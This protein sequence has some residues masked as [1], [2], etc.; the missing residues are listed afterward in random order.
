MAGAWPSTV[1]ISPAVRLGKFFVRKMLLQEQLRAEC[2][3]QLPTRPLAL[4]SHPA[5][6][7]QHQPMPVLQPQRPSSSATPPSPVAE[8]KLLQ[9]S[10]PP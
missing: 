8:P 6:L 1:S 9:S 3:L 5:A 2:V 10:Q 7:H 4:L